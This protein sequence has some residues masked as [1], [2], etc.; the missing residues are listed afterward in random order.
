M[1]LGVVTYQIAQNWD[2]DQLI[3]NCQKTGLW[4]AELRTTHAHGVEPTLSAGERRQVRQ[5]FAA[6]PVTLWC[7]GTTCEYHAAEAEVV[8]TQIEESKKWLQLA[9]DTGATGIKVRPNGFAEGVEQAVTLR[10]IGEALREV[11]EAAEPLGV[12]VMLEVHGPGTSEPAH[13]RTIMDICNHPRV[14]VTWNCN[15]LDIIDGQIA[16]NYRLLQPWIRSVHVHDLYEAYPYR[17]LISLLQ[18]DGFAGYC[19][20]EMPASCEPERLLQYYTRLWS[21]WLA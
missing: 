13:I 21:A 18:R 1:K 19:L 5:K 7:L 3:E 9:A 8:R 14:G 16:T 15:Q 12:E 10:Q 20:I 4:A 6:S 11:G 17:E 2:L